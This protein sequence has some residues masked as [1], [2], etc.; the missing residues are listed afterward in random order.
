V[1]SFCQ[2]QLKPRANAKYDPPGLHR[3]FQVLGHQG[4]CSEF[5][6]LGHL[7]R[8]APKVRQKIIRDSTKTTGASWK[9]EDA[10]PNRIFRWT[11]LLSDA[12]LEKLG[13]NM[14]ALKPW[15]VAK[16]R[17]K[18]ATYEDCMDAARKLTWFAYGM[19]N[20]PQPDESTAHYLEELFGPIVAGTTTCL[21]CKAQLNFGDFG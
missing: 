2:K 11:M 13:V 8:V 12:E 4:A 9:S 6:Y 19:D 18:A 10:G 14:G 1:I 16:L 3:C 20:A 21:V 5:P 17:E 15:V 7:E